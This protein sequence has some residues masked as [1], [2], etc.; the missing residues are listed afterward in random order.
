MEPDH[1][2]LIPLICE[3]H[4]NL[5]IVGNRLTIGMVK[6]Y[7]HIDDDSR[8]LE[9]KDGGSLDLGAGRVLSFYTVPMLHW[10][11]T[12]VT[13]LPSEGVL[14]S[15]D[16]FGTF[17]AVKGALLDS[18]LADKNAIFGEMYRYYACIVAKYGQQVQSALAKL[19][20]LDIKY[21]CSTHGPIWHKYASEVI[22]IYN[23][24]S[25]NVTRKGAVI[26][27]GSM[28]GHTEKM[29]EVLAK[30]LIERGVPE[31]KMHNISTA[32]LSFVLADIW[33]YNGLLIGSPTYNAS[34]FPPVT[35]LM[36]ALKLRGLKQR[37]AGAFGDFTWASTAC[38]LLTDS[39]T[40]MGLELPAQP[41]DMKMDMT[42]SDRERLVQMADSMALAI[43]KN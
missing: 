2:G 23:E 36:A 35:T 33:R 12:M 27:Y 21:I 24:L 9:V 13:W 40:E 3:R 4:P 10:P 14:C 8:F 39:L 38:K 22:G 32:D 17:G 16:A 18:E 43:M 31:V 41:V 11:E 30:R 15:G 37:V 28:Y 25:S 5:K 34:T 29:A 7:Y 1:S 19:K 6:G 20:N 42:A 26:A